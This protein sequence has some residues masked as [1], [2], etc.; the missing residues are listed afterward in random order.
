MLFKSLPEEGREGFIELF[1]QPFHR[2]QSSTMAKKPLPATSQPAAPRPREGISAAIL[3]LSTQL[4]TTSTAAGN[5][6][7]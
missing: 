7:Y 4:A 3:I 1:G 2:Q 5:R 6:F